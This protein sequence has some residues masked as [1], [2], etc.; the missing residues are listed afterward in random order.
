MTKPWL[1]SNA[2]VSDSWVP[3]AQVLDLVR[4]LIARGYTVT[5]NAYGK[6]ISKDW[7]WNPK[8]NVVHSADVLYISAPDGRRRGR[9]A[10]IFKWSRSDPWYNQEFPV[11]EPVDQAVG[12]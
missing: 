2:E 3:E 4:D 8:T 12:Q 10:R 1:L 11:I 5:S 7:D 9:L 6:P